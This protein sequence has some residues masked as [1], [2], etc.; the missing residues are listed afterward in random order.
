MKKSINK[1]IT[2]ITMIIISVGILYGCSPKTVPE[3][4]DELNNDNEVSINK[5]FKNVDKISAWV[6][7]WDPKVE[8]EVLKLNYQLNELCYFATHYDENGKLIVPEELNKIYNEVGNNNYINY[9]SVVN[10]VIYHD[11]T[12]SLKDITLVSNILDNNGTRSKEI[13]NI[14]N[15][16]LK[17]NFQGIEIDYEQIGK[18]LDLWNKFILFIDE[19]NIKA[20]ENNLKL[21]IVLEPNTPFE[22]LEFHKGPT[23]VMMCYNLHGGFSEPGEK[24]NSNFIKELIDKMSK[25]PGKKNFAIPSG[26]IDWASNGKVKSITEVEAKSIAREYD[27]KERRDEESNCLVYTYLDGDGISHEVWYADVD[28]LDSWFKIISDNGY[29]ASLWRLGHNLFEIDSSQ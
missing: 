27:S 28:T 9:L 11:G 3:N 7:Y 22:S 13:N 8:N 2:I 1:R 29:E 23:Y 12:S 5:V 17:Y 14:I 10:D 21:R 19:L 24:T 15:L 25:V 20:L 6:T 4:K 16:A 26:G 18:N